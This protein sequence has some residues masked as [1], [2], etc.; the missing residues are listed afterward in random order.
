MNKETRI[1]HIAYQFAEVH[2]SDHDI[3]GRMA[4]ELIELVNELHPGVKDM[5]PDDEE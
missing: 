5:E 3:L 2:R 1:I 4:R